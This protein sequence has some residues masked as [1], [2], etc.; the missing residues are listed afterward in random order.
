MSSCGVRTA[1]ACTDIL[2]GSKN[3]RLEMSSG[4]RAG[5]VFKLSQV[6]DIKSRVDLA[7]K[8]ICAAETASMYHPTRTH[9]VMSP[10]A[11]ELGYAPGMPRGTFH[12]QAVFVPT[13]ALARTR[14]SRSFRAV[15]DY[16]KTRQ[17]CRVHSAFDKNRCIVRTEG[18][19]RDIGIIVNLRPFPDCLC[20]WGFHKR[21]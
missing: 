3:G 16:Q 8:S 13:R 21:T 9:H 19:R 11:S 7:P 18:L 1:A 4:E 14:S 20:Q 10:K 6:L 5:D 2:C 15:T 12:P 17:V